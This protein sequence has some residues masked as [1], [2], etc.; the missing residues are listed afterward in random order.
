MLGNEAVEWAQAHVSL[1]RDQAAATGPHPVRAR[2]ASR[3]TVLMA[4]LLG[5]RDVPDSDLA[6]LEG[7]LPTAVAGALRG[8]VSGHMDNLESAH[9]GPLL[10][11]SFHSMVNLGTRVADWAQSHAGSD[12]SDYRRLLD[13]VDRHGIRQDLEKELVF[14]TREAQREWQGLGR[15]SRVRGRE[16]VNQ[17]EEPR[18]D[19]R[20]RRKATVGPFL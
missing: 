1:P 14:A 19:T 17:E 15:A 10:A 13:L 7:G 9:V 8:L 20:A 18:A 12:S 3:T 11:A 4:N 16:E 5:H 6:H 2:P